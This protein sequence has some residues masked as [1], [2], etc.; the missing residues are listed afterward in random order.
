MIFLYLNTILAPWTKSYQRGG[1]KLV[2]RKKLD[3]IFFNF[4]FYPVIFIVKGDK[5]IQ[6]KNI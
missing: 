1:S 6:F 2:P 4:L 3:F 5:Y